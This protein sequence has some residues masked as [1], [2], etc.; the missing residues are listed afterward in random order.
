[1]RFF[2]LQAVMLFIEAALTSPLR[3]TNI[4]RRSPRWLKRSVTFFY[5]HL[6]F[7]YTADLLCADFAAGGVWLFEPIP[8]SLF[9]GLGLG[10]Q[11]DG[12]WCW[13]NTGV[14]WYTA[15]RWWKSGIAP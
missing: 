6:W 10:T 13:G 4:A 11:G 2:F 3:K 8:V 1:M 15:E 12:W 7:Y 5:V 9:R 14:R